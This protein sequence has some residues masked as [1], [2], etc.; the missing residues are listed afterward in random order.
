MVVALKASIHKLAWVRE[1]AFRVY[2]QKWRGTRIFLRGHGNLWEG[3]GGVLSAKTIEGKGERAYIHKTEKKRGFS[4]EHVYFDFHFQSGCLKNVQFH[5]E[6]Q[7][8]DF[9]YI[10][11]DFS[12]GVE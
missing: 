7:N 5:L 9:P 11:A 3:E 4:L 12:S 10:V 2:T 6:P 8:L 1:D